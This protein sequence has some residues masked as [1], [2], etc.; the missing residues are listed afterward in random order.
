MSVEENTTHA[1]DVPVALGFQ[2]EPP[3]AAGDYVPNP[4]VPAAPKKS[5]AAIWIVAIVGVLMAA[6]GFLAV[7]LCGVVGFAFYLGSSRPAP[8]IVEYSGSAAVPFDPA[9][10]EP[11][12]DV[13]SDSAYAAPQTYDSSAGSMTVDPAMV[14]PATAAPVYDESSASPFGYLYDDFPGEDYDSDW[15][16]ELPQYQQDAIRELNQQRESGF[17]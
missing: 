16:L 5:N 17:P 1:K 10:A 11:A 12:G 3:F 4:P 6:G 9:F 13:W 15:Q 7:M 14:D 2:P 8:E